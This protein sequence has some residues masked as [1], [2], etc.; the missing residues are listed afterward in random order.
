M[1]IHLGPLS[2]WRYE[3]IHDEDECHIKKRQVDKLKLEEDEKR[4]N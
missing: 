1:V 4:N 2:G 3:H